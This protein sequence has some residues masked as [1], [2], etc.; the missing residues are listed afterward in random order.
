MAL[1]SSVVPDE[2]RGSGLALVVPLTNI[3]RLL[4]SIAFGAL[5]TLWGLHNAIAVLRRGARGGDRAGRGA[6][7]PHAG[8]GAS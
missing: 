4:A 8:A 5:W 2:V 1:G 7:R 3:A 6:A